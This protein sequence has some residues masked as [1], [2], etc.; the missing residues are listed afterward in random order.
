MSPLENLSASQKQHPPRLIKR[1][2]QHS[3]HSLSTGRLLG[4]FA[5]REPAA[6]GTAMT[7]RR[8]GD[9]F[10]LSGVKNWVA[11]APIADFA[12]VWAQVFLDAATF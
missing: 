11:A 6:E 7:A 8:D 3:I 5:L 1:S 9:Q 10:V 4:C 12:I 2:N